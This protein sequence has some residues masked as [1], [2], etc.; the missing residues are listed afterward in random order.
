[1]WLCLV[2]LFDFSGPSLF[3]S[4]FRCGDI[5]VLCFLEAC[6]YIKKSK[7]LIMLGRNGGVLPV[8]GP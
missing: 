7:A 4:D 1:M 6:I 8:C 3:P 5:F 2:D